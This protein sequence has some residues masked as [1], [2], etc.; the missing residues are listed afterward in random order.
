[1]SKSQEFDNEDWPEGTDYPPYIQIAQPKL[2]EGMVATEWDNGDDGNIDLKATGIDIESHKITLTADNII[3]QNNAGEKTFGINENGDV[4]IGGNASISGFV[5]PKPLVITSANAFNYLKP[6]DIYDQSSYYFDFTKCGNVIIIESLPKYGTQ[7]ISAVLYLPSIPLN[8]ASLDQSVVM[9][10]R[11]YI[12]QH[13]VVINKTGAQIAT[14]GSIK[15]RTVGGYGINPTYTYS[16]S[17]Q[18]ISIPTGGVGIFDANYYISKQ[19]TGST[20]REV[21]DWTGT[22]GAAR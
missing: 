8:A 18:S 12:G 14:S 19:T 5:L 2:E 11:R 15:T 10:A 4:E 1:M 22:I 3:A 21:L 9:E 20:L 16:S 13:I 7:D 17:Y 6:Y